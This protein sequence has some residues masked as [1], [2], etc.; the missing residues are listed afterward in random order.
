TLNPRYAL[1]ILEIKRTIAFLVQ[2]ETADLVVELEHLENALDQDLVIVEK[3][4]RFNKV[5]AVIKSHLTQIIANVHKSNKK[6]RFESHQTEGR[7][8][9]VFNTPDYL[10]DGHVVLLKI[11]EIGLSE[12]TTDFGE[13]IGHKNDPDMDIV[14]IIYEYQWPLKFPHE[15]IQ[16]VHETTY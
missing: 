12:I 3:T 11:N 6:I 1:G 9:T 4:R 14:R 10:V 13:V 5:R 8:I 7:S 16:Q 2:K 15:V